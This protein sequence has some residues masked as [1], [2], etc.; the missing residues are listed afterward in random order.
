MGTG[1]A[2]GLAALLFLLDSNT[3]LPAAFVA[4][5]GYFLALFFGLLCLYEHH[6]W[7]STKSLAAML[8]SALFLALSILGEE[9]GVSMFAFILAYA[10]VLETG[11][12]RSRAL[13]ILPSSSSSPCG[14]LP[15]NCP[16]TA[17]RTWAIYIDPAQQ[18]LNF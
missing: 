15:I 5:R 6:Q 11:N 18:P 7:R 13:A 14:G 17:G 16:A 8:L 12:I 2:A 10:L 9:S 4:N 3:Y 1:W